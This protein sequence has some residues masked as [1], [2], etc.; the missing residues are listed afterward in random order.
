MNTAM[1]NQAAR[2]NGADAA[3][4]R[5]AFDRLEAE[6]EAVP[7]RELEPIGVDVPGVVATVLSATTQIQA[8]RP[9][10]AALPAFDLARFDKLRDY[11]LALGHTH[12]LYRTA[13]G[14]QD[15]V[16]ELAE[17]AIELREIL[18]ADAMALVRRR[19]LEEAPVLQLRSGNAYKNIAFELMGLVELFLA[20][21]NWIEG[22]TALQRLELEHARRVANRLIAAVGKREQAPV[23]VATAALLREQAFTLL[24]RAYD[25]T[26]RAVEY[27]R[28]HEKD[29]HTIAPRL[30]VARDEHLDTARTLDSDTKQTEPGTS[31][32]TM[33]PSSGETLIGH[34][35][36]GH[37]RLGIPDERSR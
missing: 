20:Q 26:R 24:L 11:A 12:A 18:R 28:W 5:P 30:D 27:V 37:G 32:D 33:P 8:L 21:W 13:S 7:E 25:E 23:G 19:F 16:G 22:R 31:S 2:E 35:T 3:Q 6:I 29:A 4:F 10:I 9:T 14:M 34:S 36:V 15:H 17:E 1:M